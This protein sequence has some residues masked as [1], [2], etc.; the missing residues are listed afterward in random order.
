MQQMSETKTKQKKEHLTGVGAKRFRLLCAAAKKAAEAFHHGFYLEAITLTES[1]LATRLES[2]LT[3]VRECQGKSEPVKFATLGYLCNELLKGDA[4]A[5]PDW[6]AFEDPI[7]AIREWAEKR[8]GAL[9]KM[10]KLVEGD[11]DFNSNYNRCRITALGGFRVLLAYDA[12]D[13]SERL[14]ANKTTATDGLN[15]GTAFDC[16]RNI[17]DQPE[18]V[19][20]AEGVRDAGLAELDAAQRGRRLPR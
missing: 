14:K 16:L 13:R 1:L 12:I 20:P 10:A 15:R 4:K 17:M 5:A 19:T 18:L 8:N 7:R 6:A 2:R 9:H 3:W 11:R